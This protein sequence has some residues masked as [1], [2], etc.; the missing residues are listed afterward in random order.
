MSRWVD[1]RMCEL[2]VIEYLLVKLNMKVMMMA[3][4]LSGV[5][6]LHSV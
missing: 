6:V 4:K 3:G 5:L 1:R 2:G